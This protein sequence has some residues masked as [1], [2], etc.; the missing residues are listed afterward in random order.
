MTFAGLC[1]VIANFIAGN[2]ISIKK[3]DIPF[4]LLMS[5][6]HIFIPYVTEFVGLNQM[7]PSC[8]ALIYNLAPCFTAL[9]AYFIFNEVMNIK[10]W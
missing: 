5:F 7:S 6:V 1:I 4:F 9:F 3:S 2:K 8:A 10:K